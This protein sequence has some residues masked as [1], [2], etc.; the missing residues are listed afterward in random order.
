M[1]RKAA[2]APKF[3]AADFLL[4]NAGKASKPG[5]KDH[6]VI[7]GCKIL[8]DQVYDAYKAVKDAEASY[9]ALEGQ[10]LSIV[11]PEYEAGAKG[12]DFAK[13]FN[14]E[15]EAT[16]GV[17]VGY[18]DSFK[19]IPIEREADLRATLGDK[20]DLFYFQKRELELADTSNETIAF[21]HDKLGEDAFRKLFKIGLS[22]GTKPDM[23]RKQFDLPEDA[24]PE[25]YKAAVKIRNAE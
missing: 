18:K 24:R 2:A 23:D 1:A 6:P 19:K 14:V 12:G 9:A 22:V 8:A 21:L 15:G 10:L 13:S 5:K 25:Q 11:R 16:P 7:D 4:A 17:Q 3:D 20:F